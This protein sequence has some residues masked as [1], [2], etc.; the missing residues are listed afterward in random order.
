MATRKDS[1]KTGL[2]PLSYMGV[3]PVS[4]PL[5][6]TDNRAPTTE[7][8]KNFNVGTLWIDRSTAP[9]ED[10]WMLVNKDNNVAR[11]LMISQV[12]SAALET[13]TGNAG[14]AVSG[15]ALNNIDILGSGAYIITGNPG[16]NTLTLS[17]DGT[18]ATQYDADAGSAVPIAGVLQIIGDSANISTLGGSNIIEISLNDP[19]DG[20][21]ISSGGVLSGSSG[22]DGE[23]LIGSTAGLP[24]WNNITSTG[25]TVTITNGP[26]AINLETAGAGGAETFT[27]DSGTATVA[28][29]NINVLGGDNINTAAS[30]DNVYVHLNE[31]IH[32]P[33]TNAAGTTGM[34][35][36]GGSSGTGGNRFLHNYG[37][38]TP[39]ANA[40][41]GE[42]AGNLSTTAQNLVGIGDSALKSVTTGNANTAVGGISLRSC[43][44]GGSNTAVGDNTLTALTTGS[45]NT[46]IGAFSTEK[47]TTSDYN[48]AIGYVTLFRLVTGAYNTAVGYNAGNSLTT[49]D[50]S[51]ILIMNSGT[52]GDNNKI[53]IGTDGSGN[54]QQDACYVAGIYGATVDG[55]TDVPVIIDANHKLGTTTSSIRFK[56]NV[57][58]FKDKSSSVLKLRPVT[59]NYKN[60]KNK[61]ER[62]GL[63]AEEVEKIVPRLVIY[64]NE[65]NPYTVRYNDLPVLLLNEMKKMAKRISDLEKLVKKK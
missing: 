8:Y 21:V 19:G 25:G 28:A 49:N 36:L 42:L 45:S 65:N 57:K 56:E 26:N 14:G 23:V 29:N 37:P 38:A 7:D 1:R 55:A 52:A 46:A 4:P 40:F 22:N 48:T 34:I 18:I 6:L 43:T 53:R 39:R 51:N 47:I 15:D 2:W 59:F 61:H 44:T 41:L 27:T 62:I 64:D 50:S 35:Y 9:S 63:I 12:V 11:W 30:G 31:T 13:L 16:T 54:G 33:D 5:L 58:D 17:D 10:I 3:E 20:V 60:D 24:A 32:W